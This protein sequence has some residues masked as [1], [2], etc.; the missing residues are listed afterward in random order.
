[1]NTRIRLTAAAGVAVLAMALGGCSDDAPAASEG[2]YTGP[3]PCSD[4]A[5][6][7][8]IDE[9]L[10]LNGCEGEGVSVNESTSCDGHKLLAVGPV[11]GFEGKPANYLAEGEDAT[12][13]PEWE[14]FKADCPYDTE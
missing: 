3:P 4:Y 14:Q 10:S 13:S 9:E 1:M 12:T 5:N 7:E 8:V 11:Y 2:G 6:G